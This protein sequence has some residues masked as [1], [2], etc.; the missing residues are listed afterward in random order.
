MAEITNF[1][2]LNDTSKTLVKVEVSVDG[3]RNF[4]T[5]W[6]RGVSNV[7]NVGLTLDKTLITLNASDGN[8]YDSIYVYP[9]SSI[10]DIYNGYFTLMSPANA[11]INLRVSDDGGFFRIEGTDGGDIPTGTYT[12]TVVFTPNDSEGKEVINNTATFTIVVESKYA[13]FDV[14]GYAS[15]NPYNLYY[16]DGLVTLFYDLY[17]YTKNGEQELIASDY[18][19][20][21]VTSS[22]FGRQYTDVSIVYDGN[23]YN[24]II[25]WEVIDEP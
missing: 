4:G 19:E 23:T 11:P 20:I 3:G 2:Y 6:S 25:E 16:G 7:I 17:G 1:E 14:A 22:M 8:R 24:G 12:Y 21:E 18:R 9:S 10:Y 15:P 13:W 5:L